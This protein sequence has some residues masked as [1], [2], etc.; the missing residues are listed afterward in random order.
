MAR[1][2][3]ALVSSWAFL[4]VF[5]IGQYQLDVQAM[6]N[7]HTTQPIQQFDNSDG[8]DELAILEDVVNPKR[9]MS[10]RYTD[11]DFE[12]LRLNIFF[13][14]RNQGFTG[15]ARIAEVTMY[16]VDSEFYPNTV[17]GVVWDRRQM[18]WTH[19]GKSDKPNLA[20][21][22]EKRAWDI[23]GVVAGWYLADER[24][25]IFSKPVTMYHADYVKPKWDY[26]KIFEYEKY[27]E[28]VYYVEYRV[29][30]SF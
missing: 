6:S 13:E 9:Y 1:K 18:S 20:N 23:A 27:G 21:K 2:I 17:C 10:K 5:L 16:R 24:P 30:G 8:I 15:M 7:V 25:K 19:D 11:E 4:I 26:S 22:I 28:H 14:S 12:C 3:L 29:L